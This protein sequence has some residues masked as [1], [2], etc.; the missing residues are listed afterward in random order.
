MHF[1]AHK[2][3]TIMRVIRMRNVRIWILVLIAAAVASGCAKKDK[4]V[5][6]ASVQ[7]HFQNVN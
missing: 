4:A 3:N 1:R 5:K 2:E 7:I 6:T